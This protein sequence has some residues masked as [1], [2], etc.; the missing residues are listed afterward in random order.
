[1]AEKEPVKSETVVKD[2]PMP[3]AEPAP[4]GLLGLAVAA[5]VLGLVDLGFYNNTT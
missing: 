5:I 4:L 2:L 3:V 1:M